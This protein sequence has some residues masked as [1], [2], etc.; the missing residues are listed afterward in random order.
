MM[1]GMARALRSRIDRRRRLPPS[2][3][4]GHRRMEETV[5]DERGAWYRL[6]AQLTRAALRALG[7]LAGS[8]C[9]VAVACGSAVAPPATSAT[10]APSAPV[11]AT[12]PRPTDPAI[13]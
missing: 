12:T 9:L 8:A 4:C 7:T 11:A 3:G 10:V 6:P 2:A 5:T 1:Y 13:T